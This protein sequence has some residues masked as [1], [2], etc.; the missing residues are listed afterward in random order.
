MRLFCAAMMCLFAN[1]KAVGHSFVEHNTTVIRSFR[2]IQAELDLADENTL[3]VFD[4]DEVLMTY[5]DMVL[6]PCGAHFRPLS[7][8]DLN[9]SEIC[10]LTS[11]MLKEGR[12]SLVDPCIPHLIDRLED[13]G[14]KT[15]ALTAARTGKFGVIENA[16][17]WRLDV[18]KQLGITFH[19]SF[20]L[21]EIIHFKNQG[22]DDCNYPIFKKGVLFLGDAKISKGSLLLQF[23]AKVDWRPDKIIFIDNEQRHLD[24]VRTI[25]RGANISFQGYQYL[26]VEELSG[27]FEEQVA[28]I[29]FAYLRKTHRWLSDSEARRFCLKSN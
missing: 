29:Q 13:R 18:L 26:G 8:S 4:V 6:R 12:V 28:K 22:R 3:V 20:P 27:I 19:K 25:A 7:W 1:Q 2:E 10:Y 23:L 15:I 16:E 14:V 17:E 21:H 5:R 11:L 9:P 24:S